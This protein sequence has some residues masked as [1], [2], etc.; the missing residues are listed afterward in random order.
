MMA[1]KS[2]ESKASAAQSQQLAQLNAL[3]DSSLES[4][5]GDVTRI[6]D[7]T[8]PMEDVAEIE[9]GLS[10]REEMSNYSDF[11]NGAGATMDRFGTADD[12]FTYDTITDE[13]R[14]TYKPPAPETTGF[15]S[16]PVLDALFKGLG[17]TDPAAQQAYADSVNPNVYNRQKAMM[18]FGYDE[19]FGT[20]LPEW[21]SGNWFE[22]SMRDYYG[23]G[24]GQL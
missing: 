20:P 4:L 1:A 9:Y 14:L 24:G 3:K 6:F 10:G 17:L 5:W 19:E 11:L 23:K 22:G 8:S 12:P 13:E 15:G 21:W 18:G 2:A 7:L 16:D